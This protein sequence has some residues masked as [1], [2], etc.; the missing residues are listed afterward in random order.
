MAISDWPGFG[1]DQHAQRLLPALGL[2]GE[3]SIQLGLLAGSL[4][5]LKNLAHQAL[6]VTLERLLGR[7]GNS[8]ANPVSL[9]E[10]I[11][12]RHRKASVGT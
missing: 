4:I 1:F 3:F 12:T 9:A 7:D 11:Q 5:L 6:G 2:V 8:E 10:V